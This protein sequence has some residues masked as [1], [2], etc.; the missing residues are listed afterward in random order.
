MD[1]RYSGQDVVRCTSCETALAPMYCEVCHI[2]LCKD[3]AVKH[4]FDKS[5]V[6]KIVS[7]KQFLSSPKCPDHSN[8]QCELHCKQCDIP[9]CSLCVISQK[10]KYHEVVD[11]MDNFKKQ[12]GVLLRDLQEL[13]GIIFPKFEEAVTKIL[14]VRDV[15]KKQTK[16]MT[17]DL[18]KQGEYLHREI[19]IIIQ[20]MHLK[21]P[22]QRQHISLFYTEKKKN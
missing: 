5:K 20:S 6:H 17:T 4:I 15:F 22:T 3:C 18:T 13:E 1:P 16:K 19:D 2:D 8:K 7:L 12:Q 10:H 14:G 21:L 11:I 9:I